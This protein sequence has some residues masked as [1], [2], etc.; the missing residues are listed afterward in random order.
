[1]VVLPAGNGALGTLDASR[2]QRLSELNN[3]AGGRMEVVR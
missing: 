3:R 2:S 1:M